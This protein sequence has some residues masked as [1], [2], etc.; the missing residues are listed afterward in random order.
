M[1][2]LYQAAT[3]A[4]K[5]KPI[6]ERVKTFEDA[7]KE[8]GISKI[9]LGVTGLPDDE[10][11]IAAYAQLIVIA[12]ALNEGWQPDWSNHNQYKYVPWFEHKSGFGLSFYGYDG[13]DTCA[14]VGSRLCF[15]TRELSEYAGKQFA[16]LYNQF[17]SIKPTEK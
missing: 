5:S 16:A 3:A 2:T 12:R 8:L 14:H 1:T 13:W 15:K 17:L 7:C 4:T 9:E 10:G 11:S 6:T